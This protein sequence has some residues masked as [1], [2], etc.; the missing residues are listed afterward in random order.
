MHKEAR[1]GRQQVCSLTC[2]S[3]IQRG[4]W[5]SSQWSAPKAPSTPLPERHPAIV[6]AHQ[7]SPRVFV[8]GPCVNCGQ[9]FTAYDETRRANVCSPHCAR[10]IVKASHRVATDL[11]FEHV[12]WRSL[13]AEGLTDCALCGEPVDATDCWWTTGTDG[14]PAYCTG[15][16]YPSLDHVVPIAHGGEHSRANAQLTHRGCNA[17][18]GDAITSAIACTA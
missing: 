18:K 7:R 8:T 4:A 5:P 1:P 14:R 10:R 11:R 13:V 3:F 17:D 6:I 15:D 16:R 2:R 9:T 12:T